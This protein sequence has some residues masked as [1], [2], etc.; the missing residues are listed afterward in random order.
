MSSSSSS[1]TTCSFIRRSGGKLAQVE[2]GRGAC[3]LGAPLSASAPALSPSWSQDR[4]SSGAAS[5]SDAEGGQCVGDLKLSIVM[6]YFEEF[7]YSCLDANEFG[8]I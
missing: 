1:V 7:Y 6:I 4:V 2:R 5:D 3:S 8:S